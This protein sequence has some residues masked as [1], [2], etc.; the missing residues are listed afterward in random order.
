MQ[1]ELLKP[2]ILLINPSLWS[3]LLKLHIWLTSISLVTVF[4]CTISLIRHKTTLGQWAVWLGFSTV[5]IVFGVLIYLTLLRV[6]VDSALVDTVYLTA[7]RHAFGTALLLF[8]LGGL[9]AL[10]T[11]KF[12]NLSLMISFAFAL[13]ITLSGIVLTV[14]QANLGLMGMPRR[15]ADYPN[16]FA[17]LQF[18]S[19]IAAIAC[20]SLSA[21]YVILL[22][23]SAG[24][25]L[26]K[27]EEVF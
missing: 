22:W 26:E 25:S 4:L 24:N 6:Q 15:Y 18:Y 7:H 21:A 11:I 20:F 13:L 2:G 10:T 14:L 19:S 1:V 9:S 5:P 23:R 8:A 12:E 16:V 3:S 17:P 27:I